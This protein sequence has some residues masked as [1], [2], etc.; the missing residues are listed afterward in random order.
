MMAS[1]NCSAY[2][3]KRTTL[4]PLY[5]ALMNASL[6]RTYLFN[7]QDVC[8]ERLEPRH[9]EQRGVQVQF[10]ESTRQLGVPE[11]HGTPSWRVDSRN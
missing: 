5:Q 2:Q 8:E 3:A 10:R 7:R 11:L 9:H 4:S 6:A 1:H